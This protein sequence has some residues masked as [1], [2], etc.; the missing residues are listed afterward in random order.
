MNNPMHLG[1]NN[2]LNG[3]H[4]GVGAVLLC[5]LFGRMRWGIFGG[6]KSDRRLADA[7]WIDAGYSID[8]PETLPAGGMRQY[9]VQ[10][11]E[12]AMPEQ[13]TVGRA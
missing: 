11:D 4:G 9:F 13:I 7:T 5:E 6:G 3:L 8:A 10:F 12:E 2:S 1:E